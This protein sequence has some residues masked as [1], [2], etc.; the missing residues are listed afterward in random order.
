MAGDD[1]EAFN[2]STRVGIV[3]WRFGAL[4]QPWTLRSKKSKGYLTNS[5]IEILSMVRTKAG[6]NVHRTILHLH[7][8]QVTLIYNLHRNNFLWYGP[9]P[10]PGLGRGSNLS[11][12]FWTGPHGCGAAT[13]ID[14]TSSTA[15]T[16]AAT[17]GRNYSSSSCLEQL[18]QFRQEPSQLFLD[19]F[20]LQRTPRS[21]IYSAPF[22]DSINTTK[23][24]SKDL[25]FKAS[26]LKIQIFGRKNL[27]KRFVLKEGLENLTDY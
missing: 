25:R 14:P 4:N 27:K 24:I 23:S 7:L 3:D 19:G 9:G 17:V 20:A 16:R 12:S 1:D 6:V 5:M 2:L 15:R 18:Q 21:V 13:S 10:G 11:G 26:H 8:R 22:L